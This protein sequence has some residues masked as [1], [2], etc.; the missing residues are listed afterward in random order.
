MS[1]MHQHININYNVTKL[2]FSWRKKDVHTMAQ[3][4]T[5]LECT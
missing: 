3:L 4:Q 2:Y 5:W 1:D